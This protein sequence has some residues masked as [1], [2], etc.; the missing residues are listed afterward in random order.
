VTRKL[1]IS[2]DLALPIDAVTGSMIVL[3][4]RG[5]GKT[6]L[7]SVIAEELSK[8]HLHFSVIDPMGV[9]WGLQSSKDGKGPGIAVLL[10]GGLRGD[11]PIEPTAGAVCADLVVDE[12]V[13][14]VIDIS[15][16]SDGKAWS[17]GQKIRFVTEYTVRLYERQIETR[18]PLL[19]IYDEAARY[20][21]QTI[22]KG[23]KDQVPLCLAAVSMLTEESR[24]IG[25]GVCF[26]TQRSARINKSVTELCECLIAFRTIGPNSV[27]AVTD[28]LGAHLERKQIADR[29]N[30]L[31]S[32]DVG[33][34]LVVSPG[35]LKFEGIVKFRM[36]ETFDSSKTPKPGER[37]IMPVNAAKPNLDKYRRLMADTVERAEANDPKKLKSRLSDAL[38]QIDGLKRQLEVAPT[39]ECNHAEEIER[40]RGQNEALVQTIKTAEVRVFDEINRVNTVIGNASLAASNLADLLNTQVDDS[41]SII[42]LPADRPVDRPLPTA[43]GRQATSEAL[44]SYERPRPLAEPLTATH[45]GNGTG[46]PGLTGG[47]RKCLVAIAQ[48]A[49][50]INR[51][52]LSVLTD[53]KKSSRNT[54]VSQLV[55]D[56]YI[57]SSGDR[58]RAT[59]AGVAALGKF[60]RLP[61]G[62][63]L[64]EYYLNRLRGGELEC[65]KSIVAAGANGIEREEVA[66]DTYKKSS[67]N[68][69]ISKLVSREAVVTQGSRIRL[70]D[71]LL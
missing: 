42:E 19:Q 60:E 34:A 6:N 22:D 37:Q 3:G 18:N 32:L 7:G 67:R 16:H 43:Y 53:Y 21:P 49:E 33:S 47:K 52:Q 4:N 65:F 41:I 10:L 27:E 57:E 17:K 12:N 35:W 40:L 13:S 55:S 25:V 64:V 59:P 46:E 39:G 54:Y 51:S 71:L 66:K 29:T 50:G 30:E 11:I 58:L 8:N 48:Y 61:T 68:T 56:Q 14:V 63:R 69:Y 20:V 15:R 45:S 23:D 9:W 1:R 24:N 28:W 26:L 5:M 31:R 70:A 62:R 44:V 2:D 36:R 38:D